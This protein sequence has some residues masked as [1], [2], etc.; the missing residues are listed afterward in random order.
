MQPACPNTFETHYETRP[1]DRAFANVTAQRSSAF[2]ARLLDL[3][4]WLDRHWDDPELR[5]GFW[6]SGW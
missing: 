6:R 4:D 5:S 2:R 1:E 3:I